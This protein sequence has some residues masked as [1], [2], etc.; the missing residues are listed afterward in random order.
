M[1]AYIHTYTHAYI[2]VFEDAVK[3]VKSLKALM[4]L[5]AKKDVG[6]QLYDFR[7][8]LKKDIRTIKVCIRVCVCAHTYRQIYMHANIHTYIQLYD[9]REQFK[10]DIR[11]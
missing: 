6:Q 3:L 4:L 11:T 1:H 8:Q 5:I 2:P 9:F 10:K 7:E